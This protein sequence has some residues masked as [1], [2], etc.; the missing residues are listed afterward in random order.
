MQTQTTKD[1][2]IRSKSWQAMDHCTP[3]VK[4][5]MQHVRVYEPYCFVR[6]VTWCMHYMRIYMRSERMRKALS[7]GR[8]NRAWHVIAHMKSLYPVRF[9]S[10]FV[11]FTLF[12]SAL[13]IRGDPLGI[14]ED[15]ISLLRLPFQIFILLSLLQ[16]HCL[17]F[18]YTCLLSIL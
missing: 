7:I 14:Q 3:F 5:C 10:I 2:Y 4:Q 17:K 1:L 12:T 16:K 11:W 18:L 9:K 8:E 6:C 13:H 15:F